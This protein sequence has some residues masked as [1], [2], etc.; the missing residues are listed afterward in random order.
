MTVK[1]IIKDGG[2][3]I[4]DI[5]IDKEN[6]LTLTIDIVNEKKGSNSNFEKFCGTWKDSDNSELDKNLTDQRKIDEDIWN[7]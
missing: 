7:V 3:F 6:H 5:N 1:A 4:P 2:I